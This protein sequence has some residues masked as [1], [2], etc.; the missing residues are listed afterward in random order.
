MKTDKEPFKKLLIV[1]LAQVIL[2]FSGVA[3]LYSFG[4][5]PM[6]EVI[7]EMV[8]GEEISDFWREFLVGIGVLLSLIVLGLL[9]YFILSWLLAES[10][11]E[12][13][14]KTR[15][16]LDLSEEE[17][18]RYIEAKDNGDLEEQT[19]IL[20]GCGCKDDGDADKCTGCSDCTDDACKCV[21]VKKEIKGLKTETDYLIDYLNI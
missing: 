12:G 8:N 13:K 10:I 21:K 7:H 14:I 15:H 11:F 4:K 18:W 6:E 5:P 1:D 20:K 19:R 2:I 9:T 16:I 3:C 17:R